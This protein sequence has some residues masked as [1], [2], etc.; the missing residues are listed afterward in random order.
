MTINEVLSP[1]KKEHND[2]LEF[3]KK[4]SVLFREKTTNLS[5]KVKAGWKVKPE[6]W[7]DDDDRD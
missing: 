1:L 3:V 6:D 7:Q 5:E 4:G 2:R